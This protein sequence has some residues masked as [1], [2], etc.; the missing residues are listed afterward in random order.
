MDIKFLAGAR[1]LDAGCRIAQ[2]AAGTFLAT[3][4]NTAHKILGMVEDGQGGIF[5]ARAT[6]YEFCSE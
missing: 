6:R 1:T 3:G 5:V 4:I 2:W